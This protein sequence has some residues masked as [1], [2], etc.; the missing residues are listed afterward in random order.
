MACKFDRSVGIVEGFSSPEINS[1]VAI[2]DSH[3]H[4]CYFPRSTAGSL[5]EGLQRRLC[6]LGVFGYPMWKYFYF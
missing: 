6:N 4:V 5:L 2:C 3:N 1:M